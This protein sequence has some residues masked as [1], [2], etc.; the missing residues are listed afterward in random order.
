MSASFV[1]PETVASWLKDPSLKQGVDYQVVDVRDLDFD[2]GHIRGA[3]N[4]PAHE[5]LENTEK[6]LPDLAKPKKLIFHCALSQ[7]RGPKSAN[8]YLAALREKAVVLDQEVLVLKGGFNTWQSKYKD[9]KAL[10]EDYKPELWT[11]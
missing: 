1:D 7:V 11:E 2:G 9:D 10:V 8:G 5:L 4:I 3:S 6:H